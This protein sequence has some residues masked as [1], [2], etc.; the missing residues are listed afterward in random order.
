MQIKTNAMQ[1]TNEICRVL[2]KVPGIPLF[3]HKAFELILISPYEIDTFVE[4]CHSN[5]IT[6][7]FA[8]EFTAHQ[9][10]VF[11][12][13]NLKT[14]KNMKICGTKKKKYLK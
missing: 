5:S 1:F 3:K 7:R 11:Q 4:K 14:N 8:E 2:A 6:R 10:Y 12:Y 13:L 9:L